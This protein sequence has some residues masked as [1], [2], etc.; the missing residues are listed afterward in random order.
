MFRLSYN[1]NGLRSLSL[2]R[3]VEEVSKAGYEG[4]EIA[5]DASHLNP[6]D[7]TKEQLDE[8]KHLFDSLPVKP[9]CL[10]TEGPGA[11]VLLSDVHFEPSL[12]SADAQGRKKRIDL[13]NRALEIAN[14]LS[15]PV[16]NILSGILREGVSEEEARQMLVEGVRTCLRNAGDVVLTLEPEMIAPF[17]PPPPHFIESTS[18][19]IPIIKEIDS[20]QFRMNV[21]ITHVKCLE[22]DFLQS[23]SEV[24][25]YARHMHI[26]DIKGRLHHHE[27]PGE[28]EIDF[29]SFFEVLRKGKYEHYL[30]VEV[31]RHT[32]EW[33]RALY[34]S[35]KHLLEQM[36]ASEESS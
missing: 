17:Y 28:G 35:R 5:F 9:I 23:I 33:E 26:A 4:V 2:E 19:A 6:L 3:A 1:T 36:K 13:I 18:Q 24:L 10:G 20:P 29:R 11:K 14:Y 15:I 25:P 31:Y 32:D 8:L 27:I 22:S 21:D 30:S 7:T 34:Q 16:V 12:I